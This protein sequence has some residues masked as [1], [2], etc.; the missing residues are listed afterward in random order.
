MLEKNVRINNLF[1]S[2]LKGCNF[3]CL[4]LLGYLFLSTFKEI[5]VRYMKKVITTELGHF[6]CGPNDSYVLTISFRE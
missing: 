2:G 5:C 1:Q 4:Q 6:S 3:S